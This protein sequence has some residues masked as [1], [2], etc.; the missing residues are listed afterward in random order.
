MVRKYQRKSERLKYGED[1]LKRSLEDLQQGRGL[2][3]VS[4]EYGVPCRTLRRHRDGKVRSPG[5]RH[6]G[7]YATV[8]PSDVEEALKEHIFDLESRLFGLTTLDV[9][10]LAFHMAEEMKVP[11][12]FRDGCAGEDWLR[13][14][15]IRHPDI[16]L[17]KP[18]ATSIH[19]AI[20]FNKQL[21]KQF[22]D[23]YKGLL[24]KYNFE[25]RQVWNMD[26]TGVTTVQSPSKVLAKC[27]K[28]AVGSLTSAERGQL[29]TVVAA[30]SAAGHYIPPMLIWPRKR[31]LDKLMDG[32][33]PGSIAGTSDSGWTDGELFL[34]WLKHFQQWTQSSSTNP[35]LIILDG[36][37]SHKYLPAILY[38]R[39][40]HIHML[41]LQPHTSHKMQPLD[42]TVFKSLKAGYN[43][44]AENYLRTSRGKAITVFEIG[45]LVGKALNRTAT[46]DKA[47]KGFQVTGLWP[48]DEEIFTEEDFAPSLL[49][50]EADP[51]HSEETG[52]VDDAG[53]SGA[54]AVGDAG[55]SGAGAVD[56][57]GR[58][59]A[60][61]VKDAGPSGAGAVDDAGRSGAGAVEDAGPSGAGAVGEAGPSGAGAVDDAG[62]SGADAV[63][64]AGPSGA[65]AVGDAGPSGAGAVDDAG[66]SGADA[67]EDAGPSGARAEGDAGPSGEPPVSQMI[68]SARKLLGDLSPL[69]KAQKRKRSRK[70]EKSTVLT[71]SPVKERLI[72]GHNKRKGGKP[73]PKKNKSVPDMNEDMTTCL[74][75]S[76]RFVHSC[77]E[78]I[79][80][81]TCK[82]WACVPCTDWTAAQAAYICDRCRE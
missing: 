36:H 28:R 55:P 58:S 48:F 44:A 39:E 20:S 17:R 73:K 67:V 75:C 63:E 52:A 60:G 38:A 64:D 7:R 56:D 37:Q 42:R 14:F 9:R 13:G 68:T 23:I 30:C 8:F 78:W 24:E 34:R 50:E 69:P 70:T 65:G 5:E 40:H 26:E 46:P 1:A 27:G 76:M 16:S 57:A 15:L 29:V 71:S 66:P 2:R 21:V 59:G 47:I 4:R 25:S 82:D 53:P 62:P 54:G 18:Q 61:A 3:E 74:I 10:K 6:L 45:A 22:F 35:Q 51:G 77:E 11:H 81:G 19:R 43:V 79:Q 32:T 33:P 80:C 72:E 12:P 41:T 49:T 31:L